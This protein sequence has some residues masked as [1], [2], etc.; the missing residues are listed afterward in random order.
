[1]KPIYETFMYKLTTER[2]NNL[3]GFITAESSS[4]AILKVAK[5]AIKH[6]QQSYLTSIEVKHAPKYENPREMWEQC[7]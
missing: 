7:K 4:N 1:M 6:R 5:Q 2:G 3:Y